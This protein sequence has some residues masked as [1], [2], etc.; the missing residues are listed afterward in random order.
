MANN[1]QDILSRINNPSDIRKLS[2]Q[3]L[4]LLAEETRTFLIDSI[5]QHGGHFSGNL[6]VV[7]L[8]IALH[9]LLDLPADTLIWDVGH[10][11]YVHKLFTGRRDEFARI[12]R[13]DGLSGFPKMTESQFDAFGTG[14]SSTSI[15]A[16]LGMADA[17]LLMKKD[18]RHVAVI[19]DG[20]LTGGMA[21][22]ALNN[23]GVSKANIT[24]VINDNQIGIDPNMG[25]IGRMLKSVVPG[26]ANVFTSLGLA[27]FGPVDGH[28][29]DALMP[30]LE[31]AVNFKGPSVIHVKTIKGKGYREAELEQ[32]KWHAVKYVKIGDETNASEYNGPKYQQVF[33]ETLCELAAKDSLIVGIT[34]AMPSGSSMDLMMAKFPERTFDVGIAE[35][36]ALTFSAGLAAKGLKPFCNVYSTFLQRGYDQLIHDIGLQNLPVRMFLDRAGVVGEDGPTH[37]GLYDLVYLRAVPNL[38]VEAPMNEAELKGMMIHAAGYDSGPLAIR[39]P[40]GRSPKMTGDTVPEIEAGKGCWLRDG[41]DV[42]VLSIGHIG[43]QAKSAI[44]L[45]SESG[46]EAAHADMRFLKPLDQEILKEVFDRFDVIFTIED[47]IVEGGFGGAVNDWALKRGYRSR[48]VNL[49]FPNELI[50]QDTRNGQ[51]SRYGLDPKGIAACVLKELKG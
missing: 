13:H 17:D 24:I 36:H 33:G 28:D 6:G 49:G 40:R 5:L 29:L 41:R 27:Y 22:E 12:R 20:S 18:R 45:L 7:E 42:A 15:S 3:E 32:T 43:N 14:H 16:C 51:Y 26:E 23:A 50:D 39:Y 44:Q 46:I 21:W 1:M 19:G 38:I 47:G 25:A 35:Q 34:P 37:H 2:D 30:L 8:T 4:K 31:Q 10:Q 48:I 11:S 9:R